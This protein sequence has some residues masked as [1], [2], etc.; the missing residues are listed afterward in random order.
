MLLF[1]KI[2]I[3]TNESTVDTKYKQYK[4]LCGDH[5]F[6][7]VCEESLNFDRFKSKK[8]YFNLEY[9]QAFAFFSFPQS[10]D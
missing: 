3:D 5:L 6:F 4:A 8:L 7:K 10:K 9:S 2:Q 1:Q